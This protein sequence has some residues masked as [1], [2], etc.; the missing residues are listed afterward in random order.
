MP[1]ANRVRAAIRACPFVVVSD[2]CRATD[3]T[4]LA[5]V[6][7]ASATWGEKE[8]TVTNSER[9]ISRHR[10]FLRPP[11]RSAARLAADH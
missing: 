8:G 5:D 10:A 1:E 11:R 4:A 6:L 3:T 7:L 9:R 2:V